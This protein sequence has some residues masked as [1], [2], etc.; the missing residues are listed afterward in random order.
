GDAMGVLTVA[1]FLLCLPLFREAPTW[2][3]A[4]WLEAGAILVVA[5]AVTVWTAGS[6]LPL[7]FLSL[8]VV[9]WAAWRLQLRG[10]APTALLVTLTAPRA[11]VRSGGAFAHQSLFEQMFTLQTFNACVAL[12]SFFLAALVSERNRAAE[13]L[14]A[15]AADLQDRVQRGTAELSVAHEQLAHE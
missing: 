1:P 4:R 6:D 10:A 12:T 15:A 13:L 3:R 5:G 14:S 11:A 2:S 8:P 7:L 9:G